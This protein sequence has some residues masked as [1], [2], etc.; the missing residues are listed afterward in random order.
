MN[1]T[2]HTAKLSA[3][4]WAIESR[5]FAARLDRR[6]RRRSERR[7]RCDT[8]QIAQDCAP[9]ATRYEVEEEDDDGGD[10]EEAAAVAAVDADDVARRCRSRSRSVECRD[11]GDDEEK[12]AAQ[13]EV[14]RK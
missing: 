8:D 2:R 5:R 6:Q 10:G 9:R 14:E 7:H 11:D 13:A 4:K 12:K 1:K 3:S